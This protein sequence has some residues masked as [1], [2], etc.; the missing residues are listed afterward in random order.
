VGQVEFQ[1]GAGNDRFV[2]N[3]Y[4]LPIRAFGF[5]G[6]DYL[7]GYNGNDI[8]VGG[9]GDDTMVGYGGNDQFW[10]GNGNDI[11]KGM[12]GND[13]AYG[14]SGDDKLVGGDGTDNLYGGD[15]NDALIGGAGLLTYW[16][17]K[18]NDLLA[19]CAPNCSQASV[20]H[21]RK[22]YF[23]ADASLGVGAVALATSLVLF[24]A[25]PSSKDK[26][27]AQ[28]SQVLRRAQLWIRPGPRP[29]GG[30]N[31]DVL[32]AGHPEGGRTSRPRHSWILRRVRRLLAVEW[33]G[34]EPDD[35]GHAECPRPGL[36][37]AVQHSG[38]P[39]PA[40]EAA[41]EGARGLRAQHEALSRL[42]QHLRQPCR[43]VFFERRQDARD[44][45]LPQGA[46]SG[47]ARP[48]DDPEAEG[49]REGECPRPAQ[50]AW[51]LMTKPDPVL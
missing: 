42:G 28:S 41:C 27:G 44:C 1:G 18:D 15:G 33:I 49:S 34:H 47:R 51:R 20:D 7:E 30:R 4:S 32:A 12:A 46:R 8:F 21:I 35:G 13:T 22:L 26:P 29:G 10:G 23:A 36:R 31:R 6:N 45:V 17:R 3:V 38:L 16:G 25:S 40:A 43:G 14:E 9:D 19:R 39:A 11:V 2:N 24:L 48:E 50:G 5:G 37:R